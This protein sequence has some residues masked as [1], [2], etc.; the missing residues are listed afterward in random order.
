MKGEQIS[1]LQSEI[2]ELQSQKRE[3]IERQRRQSGVILE[4]KKE[5]KARQNE[6]KALHSEMEQ[7]IQ[8]KMKSMLI[9]CQT[10]ENRTN[11]NRS[12]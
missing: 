3:Y 10:M 7:V 2:D 11:I 1:S 5:L 8:S 6:N 9:L 12:K 4:L